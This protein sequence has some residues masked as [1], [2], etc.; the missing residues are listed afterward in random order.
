MLALNMVWANA[1][2]VIALTYM[3]FAS[4]ITMLLHAF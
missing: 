1:I 3:G 4:L 2:P